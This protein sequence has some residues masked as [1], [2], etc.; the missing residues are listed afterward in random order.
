MDQYLC[1]LTLVY[2][3]A[4]EDSLVEYML[5]QDPPLSGFTTMKAE[6]HGLGFDRASAREK[7][8]G[9][10][11]RR[12]FIAI[13]SIEQSEQVL[14]KLKSDMPIAGLMYWT[15]PILSAGRLL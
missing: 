7:V 12:L 9:R 14:T 2:P 11:D 13:I 6:G 10:T 8:H 3:P 15:E 1:K 5:N 4:S